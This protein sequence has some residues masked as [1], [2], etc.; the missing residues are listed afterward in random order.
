MIKILTPI[1]LDADFKLKLDMLANHNAVT[2]EGTGSVVGLIRDALYKTYPALNKSIIE[3]NEMMCEKTQKR[4]K[5]KVGA[6]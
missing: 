5:D 1:K 6:F 3:F 2:T 4:F